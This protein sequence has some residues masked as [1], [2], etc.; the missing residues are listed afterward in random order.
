MT[1]AIALAAIF[2]APL[3][4]AAL[5]MLLPRPPGLRDVLHIGG[6][7]VT[8]GFAFYLLN[9][10]A[11]GASARVVFGQP[12]PNVDLAFTAEPLG[13][14]VAAV[15]AGL[16]VLH[17]AHTTGYV[18][19]TG[20]KAASGLM[21]FNALSALAAMA[22]AYSANLFTMFVAY[23]ALVLV[24]S[25]LAARRDVE[26]AGR[27]V[28]TFL[29]TL[30]APSMGLFL[31]A[32]VWTYTIAGTAEFQAGGILAG[33]GLDEGVANVL[34]VLFVV[35][36]AMSAMPPFYQWLSG[37][38]GASYP[39]L[40]SIQS[41][42]VLPAGGL[43]VLKIAAFVFGSE[44]NVAKLAAHALVALAGVGMCVAALIALSKQDLR[45]RLAYSC[46]AQAL[47]AVMGAL[48][49]LSAGLF[50]AALQ[51]VAM[52]CAATTLM[53]AA[54]TTAA[55]T[56]RRNAADYPGLGRVMPWTFAGFAVASASM[57][58]M[59]PFAGAWAKVWLIIAAATPGAGLIWAAV[60][61]GVAA[62]L[63]FAHLGPLAAAALAARAPTDAFKRPDGA[64]ILLATPVIIGAAATL[65]L[66]V[67]A[68][69]LATFLS[70]VWTPHS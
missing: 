17:A 2:F 70:P 65:W 21:A 58:G 20:E 52:S 59:P 10:V 8:A 68:D 16:S 56:G 57:I 33:R 60:L 32:M 13:A 63:T 28:R 62:V 9:A 35:G 25:P 54:G 64:S 30:L 18:R 12:L 40:V 38:S 5:V 7:L 50:A 4:Q 41:L 6:S 37:T 36:L 48:L 34:L 51:I 44:L 24:A 23:Q 47:A 49:A 53:M 22:V 27:S 39:S 66:L 11:H 26:D 3:I 14:L 43:A 31:P 1:P 42:A 61:I 45:E 69:P 67:L 55:V 19:A 29:A 46:M 15:I